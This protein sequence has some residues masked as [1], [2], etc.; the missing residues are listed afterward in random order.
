MIRIYS[1]FC[2]TPDE[3]GM[4]EIYSI[5][6]FFIFEY[7]KEKCIKRI[8]DPLFEEAFSNL[9]KLIHHDVENIC[10]NI[11]VGKLNKGSADYIYLKEQ[12]MLLNEYILVLFDW[13]K[14][15]T[16]LRNSIEKDKN[17]PEL[18]TIQKFQDLCKILYYSKILYSIIKYIYPN[19]IE[20]DRLLYCL[21]KMSVHVRSLDLILICLEQRKFDYG[22]IYKNIKWRFIEPTQNII[23]LN[24]KPSVTFDNLRSNCKLPDDST[25][26]DFKDKYIQ[27]Q[28]DGYD[29]SLELSTCI[30]CEIRLIDYLIEQNI[31]EIYDFD[32]EIGISKLSCYPCTLYIDK[33]NT[34]FLCC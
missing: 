30:H 20:H 23:E 4:L 21:D 6:N 34:K 9:E 24:E 22:E 33:L 8:F 26:L 16:L 1:R 14:N 27:N 5:L 18:K 25:K 12:N 10:Q 28:F 31:H 7:N 17:N 29:K 19:V 15:L 13:I 3:E 2:F 11:T 32:I